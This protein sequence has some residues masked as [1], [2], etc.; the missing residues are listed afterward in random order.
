MSLNNLPNHLSACMFSNQSLFTPYNDLFQSNPYRKAF[1]SPHNFCVCL[2]IYICMK[3]KKMFS[4]RTIVIY[5]ERNKNLSRILNLY[6][7]IFSQLLGSIIKSEFSKTGL[8]ILAIAF[9]HCQ[10]R[11]HKF[12]HNI[13]IQLYVQ[14]ERNEAFTRKRR[15]DG[16]DMNA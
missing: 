12:P 2:N 1:V 8:T 6:L 7:L 10:I 14:R 16:I 4:L 15:D 9:I 5:N 11:M 3:Y 13:N